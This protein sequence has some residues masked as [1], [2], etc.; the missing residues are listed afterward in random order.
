MLSHAL[1]KGEGARPPAEHV[2]SAVD[3]ACSAARQMPPAGDGPRD[4]AH[5]LTVASTLA[6]R[7]LQPSPIDGQWCVFG[8]STR[9]VGRLESVSSSST[10]PGEHASPLV[11]RRDTCPVAPTSLVRLPDRDPAAV[12]LHVAEQ[13]RRRRGLMPPVEDA[14]G[15]C[16]RCDLGRQARR[17]ILPAP[18][19]RTAHRAVLRPRVQRLR[20]S[21]SRGGQ[22]LVGSGA[23]PQRYAAPAHTSRR[24][25]PVENAAM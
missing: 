4:A 2:P 3:G 13:N 22:P 10:L 12:T 7:P 5:H 23:T 1:A 8:C 16:R 17:G 21:G 20:W 18:V 25:G 15:T 6:G 14:Y 19:R 24:R 11:R 9:T